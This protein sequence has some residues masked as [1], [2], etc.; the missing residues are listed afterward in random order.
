MEIIAYGHV[1]PMSLPVC[2]RIYMYV[3]VFAGTELHAVNLSYS[4]KIWS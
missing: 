4:H 1:S 3:C 2:A